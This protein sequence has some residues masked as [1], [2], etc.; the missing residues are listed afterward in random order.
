M[1]LTLGQVADWIHADGEF[2][3]LAEAVGYGT[4]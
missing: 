1:K 4:T 3:T 2:D